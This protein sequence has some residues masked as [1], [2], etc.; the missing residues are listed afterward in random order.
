MQKQ[1]SLVEIPAE[2]NKQQFAES[3]GIF[4]PPPDIDYSISLWMNTHSIHWRISSFTRK[5]KLGNRY[6]TGFFLNFLQINFQSLW[7][8]WANPSG[9]LFYWTSLHKEMHMNVHHLKSISFNDLVCPIR[10]YL[11]RQNKE[12][13]SHMPL[14]N[15]IK[16]PANT[17]HCTLFKWSWLVYTFWE[18]VYLIQ[19]LCSELV[20]RWWLG[21]SNEPTK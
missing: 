4:T 14:Y 5:F 8:S 19:C 10:R 1:S 15:E 16:R 13:Q 2:K 9:F 7:M 18:I 6:R 20:L 11:I 3:S 17:L 21:V 12:W